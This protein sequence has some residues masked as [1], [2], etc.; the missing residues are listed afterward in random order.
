MSF[1][2]DLPHDL[3]QFGDADVVGHEE[4]GPIHERQVLLAFEPLDDQRHTVGVLLA[5][6]VRVAFAGG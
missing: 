4:L 1:L 5:Y 2:S 6:L 3:H